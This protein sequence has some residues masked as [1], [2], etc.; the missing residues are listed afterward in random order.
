VDW[1]GKA[2]LD[3]V[4]ANVDLDDNVTFTLHSNAYALNRF[5]H[6]YVSDLT[7]ELGTGG[8]Y[9][10]GGIPAGVV[11]RTLTVANSWAV[12]RANATGYTVGD[13]V[14]PAAGNGFLYRATTTGTSGGSIPAFPTN[15]GD[16]VADG[17]VTWECYARAILVFTAANP[18]TWATATFTARYLVLSDRTNGLASQ[19]PLIGVRDFGAD[20]TGGGGNFTVNPHPNLGLLHI[21]IH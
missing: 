10:A 3:M 13:V 1:Y 17:G 7:N 15:L 12:Q 20:Q 11:S 21:A 8:G 9:T 19:Q 16:T 14:R 2:Y 5:T 18:A 6:Q 4:N